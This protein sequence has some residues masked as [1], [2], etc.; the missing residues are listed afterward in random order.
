M[1]INENTNS[2]QALLAEMMNDG[3]GKR[4]TIFSMQQEIL[5]YMK[6]EFYSDIEIDDDILKIS[7]T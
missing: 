1:T 6:M 5:K 4:S 2:Y 3:N 7:R